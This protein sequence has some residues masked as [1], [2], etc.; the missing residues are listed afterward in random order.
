M[1]SRR[2]SSI[3]G[4]QGLP[5]PGSHLHAPG[6]E[7]V[8]RT[9]KQRG[10]ARANR[11]QSQN[12]RHLLD[13]PP[14]FPSPPTP[15]PEDFLDLIMSKTLG[16][17]GMAGKGLMALPAWPKCHVDRALPPGDMATALHAGPLAG[18]TRM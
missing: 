5:S 3:Q 8:Q 12:C 1:T 13:P 6:P 16:S 15:Y 7:G 4:T 18:T 11:T 9:E 2:G 10:K 17:S 14:A